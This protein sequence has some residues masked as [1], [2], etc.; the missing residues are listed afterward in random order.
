MDLNR[1]PEERVVVRVTFRDEP[2]HRFWPLVQQPKPE[3]S[4]PGCR[5]GGPLVDQHGETVAHDL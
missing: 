1:L 3:V 2:K 5:S 4:D